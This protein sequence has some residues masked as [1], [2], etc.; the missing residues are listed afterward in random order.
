MKKL[1]LVLAGLL[2]MGFPL[3]AIA[4]TGTSSHTSSIFSRGYG[5]SFIFV[6][7][8]I[9]FSPIRSTAN[10]LQDYAHLLLIDHI[11]GCRHI[12]FA[13]LIEHGGIHA[14]DGL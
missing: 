1:A 5:N 7:G 3:N 14:L 9:E 2:L 4:K 12:G 11:G 8:G 10:F 13:S 6:E